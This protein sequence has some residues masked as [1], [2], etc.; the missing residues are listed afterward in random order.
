MTYE[1]SRAAR[2]QNRN[3]FSYFSD[4]VSSAREDL[5]RE[6][7]SDQLAAIA[8]FCGIG[9]LVSLVAMMSGV[10]GVWM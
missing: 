1:K 7:T 8:I 4:A 6:F 5:R 9:L 3:W 2:Y 10:Q